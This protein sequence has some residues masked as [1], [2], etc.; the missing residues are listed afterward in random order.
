MLAWIDNSW[1]AEFMRNYQWAFPISEAMHFIG[2]CL[3]IGS[4]AVMDL[5]ILGFAPR[6]PMRVVHQLVP[7]AWIGFSINLTTGILF[8][9]AQ[10]AFY[11]PNGAFRVKMVLLLLAGIN[12]LWF[13]F[14]V[15]HDLESLPEGADAPGNAKTVAGISLA[16]W[17]AVICFGRFIMYWPPY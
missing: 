2:L 4:V 15:S 11:I 9:F 10:S 16:L 14:R 17:L 5:R 6:L 1:L 7:W 3:L 13:Q 8:F 12:A